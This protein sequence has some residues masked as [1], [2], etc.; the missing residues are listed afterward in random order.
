MV[1]ILS[2]SFI[3]L[4]ATPQ[5]KCYISSPLP[6]MKET[7]IS[8]Q[9]QPISY[10]SFWLPPIVPIRILLMNSNLMSMRG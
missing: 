7:W 9:K 6:Y 5:A 4:I 10:I 8:E 3:V 2:L 1:Q